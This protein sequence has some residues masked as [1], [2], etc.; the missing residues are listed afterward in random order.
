M[1]IPVPV[2]AK[3]GQKLLQLEYTEMGDILLGHNEG[4][5]KA[6]GLNSF[7]RD[8]AKSMISLRG[9]TASLCVAVQAPG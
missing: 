1:M 8:S 5:N 6:K 3:L 2:T 4:R 9:Y 7:V